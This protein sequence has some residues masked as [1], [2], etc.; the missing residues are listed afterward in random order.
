MTETIPKTGSICKECETGRV[1]L[2]YACV[3]EGEMDDEPYTSGIKEGDNGYVEFLE[4][5]QLVIYACDHCGKVYS[6]LVDTG[7]SND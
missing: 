5:I 1:A 2:I 4:S 6:V 7:E 3:S